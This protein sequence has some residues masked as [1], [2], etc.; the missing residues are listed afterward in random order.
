[1]KK[2]TILIVIIILVIVALLAGR[3]YFSQQDMGLSN[4]YWNGMTQVSGDIRPLYNV[5]TL[6]DNGSG[7]TFLVLNPQDN[8]TAAESSV[9]RSFIESGGLVVVMDDYGAAN[10]LLQN[11]DS[12]ITLDQ[13]PLCQDVDYHLRPS[14]PIITDITPSLVTSNVSSIVFDHPVSLN[15]TGNASVIASTSRL[16]WLDL[17]DNGLLDKDEPSGIYPVAAQANY[18]KGEL[19]VIGDPDVLINSMQDKGDNR[20]LVSNIVSTGIV[21]VDASHGQSIPPLASVLFTIKYNIFAQ[22]SC[23]LAILLLAYVF[24]RRHDIARLI[25]V[26]EE[27]PEKQRDM[28]EAIIEHM[29]KTPMKPEQVEELKRKL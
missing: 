6:S 12:P 18:G 8:F 11:I 9:V 20:V 3:F 29:K 24:Y 15:I 27:K 16:G 21:Y 25:K 13:V 7:T 17:N 14:F 4:P 26:P 23:V 19:I 1:M 22:L 5:S 2:T 28:K 10:S